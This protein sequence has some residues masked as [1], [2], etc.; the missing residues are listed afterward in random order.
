M[1]SQQSKQNPSKNNNPDL[2]SLNA[3]TEILPK[4][5]ETSSES[6]KMAYQLN[7]RKRLDT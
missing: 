6:R 3:K 4:I 7:L 5:V 2:M 1:Q